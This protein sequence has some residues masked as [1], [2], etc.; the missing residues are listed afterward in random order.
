MT[1]HA[2]VVAR[3]M[4]KCCVSGCESIVVSEVNGQFKVG[5]LIIKEGDIITLDGST[6]EVILGQVPTVI[7]SLSGDFGVVMEWANKFKKLGVRTNA[8]TPKD[9]KT[10]RGFGAEGIGLC[11]TEHMFFDTDRI[12]AVRQMIVADNEDQRRLALA[13]IFPM[14]K[15]DFKEL[16]EIMKGLPVKIRLL[17]PPLHE[18]LPKE[19]ADVESIAKEMDISV[20][21]LKEKIEYLHE[22]NPMMGHRGCRLGVTFP[23]IFEMQVKAIAEAAC[24]LIKSGQNIVPEIMIPLVGEVN[25]YKYLQ[26]RLVPI[27][28]ATIKEFGVTMKYELGTMIEIPRAALTADEIAK[29]A[30]FFSFGTNDL[31]QMTYG[32][33]RDDAGKFLKDYLDKK[34]LTEDPFRSVDQVGVGK[35]MKMSVELGRSV[36]PDLHVGICGEQGGDPETIKFC[37]KIGLNYVSCSP[38][39]VPIAIISAAQAAIENEK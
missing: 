22:F 11:R 24:E 33:S 10:A 5:D 35:L 31:T 36:R 39:R 4:G 6:G 25:E 14:Q 15:N 1:S 32:F 23:E 29:E 2:A 27:I 30:E 12:F 19:E 20:D 13:K 7:P 16:F 8:D 28:E 18:F 17:D 37:H 34:I 9:A 26:S 38:Y 3:G 21:K